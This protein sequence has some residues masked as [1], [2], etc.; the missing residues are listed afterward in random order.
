M[1]FNLPYSLDGAGGNGG[2][3]GGG[4]GYLATAGTPYTGV[5]NIICGDCCCTGG[6]PYVSNGASRR[7]I[8]V[9]SEF[10]LITALVIGNANA[11]N[12][13]IDRNV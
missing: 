7:S 13:T 10:V 11:Q 8:F 9:V 12:N 2:R 4:G 6:G 5:G 1:K 3:S